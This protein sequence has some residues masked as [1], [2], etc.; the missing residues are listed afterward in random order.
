MFLL[1]VFWLQ[2]QNSCFKVR[3]SLSQDAIK[4]RNG[5][6]YNGTPKT[7]YPSIGAA[8]W[9]ILHVVNMKLS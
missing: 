4:D 3:F 8:M 2:V 6:F 1:A 7:T 5:Q 9:I